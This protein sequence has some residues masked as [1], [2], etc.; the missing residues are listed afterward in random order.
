MDRVNFWEP[1]ECCGPHLQQA[2]FDGLAVDEFDCPECGCNWT[3]HR[4]TDT[5]VWRWVPHPIVEIL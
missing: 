1:D 2:L 3:S 4:M 5:N